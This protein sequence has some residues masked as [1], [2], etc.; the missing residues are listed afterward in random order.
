MQSPLQAVIFDW[1]GTLV[2]YGSRAPMGVFVEAFRRFGVEITIAE[3]RGPMGMAK[4]DHIKAVGGLPAV[5]ERWQAKHGRSFSEADVDAIY[6]VFVPLNVEVVTDHAEAIPGAAETMAALRA[7][8]LRLGSTTGYTREIMAPLLPRAAAQGIAPDSLVCAGDLPQGRPSPAMMYR[9]FLELGVGPAWRC[10][11][12]DD[13]A[14]G[15]AEG[16]NAGTWTVG[17][18]LTGNAF[19]LSL[20]EQQALAPADF[21][22]RRTAAVGEFLRAGAHF[23]IDGVADLPAVI[24]AVEGRLVRGE[25]P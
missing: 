2:D 5:A 23:V 6:E 16:L 15:I 22:A 24:D 25:R 10:V 12:V 20:E 14:V 7:R 8:G 11:K 1:A 4:R 19:G 13:T 21:A 18:A 9:T 3:A 17:V